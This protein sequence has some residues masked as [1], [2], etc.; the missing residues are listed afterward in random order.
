[1][2]NKAGTQFAT[3]VFTVDDC[4]AQSGTKGTAGELKPY[5]NESGAICSIYKQ[6]SKDKTV[7]YEGLLK[8]GVS[9][10]KKGDEIEIDSV[11][12]RVETAEIVYQN[13]DVQKI[14]GTARY[15]DDIDGQ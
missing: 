15:Y 7:Q 14:R 6:D 5:R 3:G 1:M 12:Y 11:T 8:S 13:D 4:I 10:P 2:T 9:L